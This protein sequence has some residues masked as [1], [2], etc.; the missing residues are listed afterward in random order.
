MEAGHWKGP[1]DGIGAAVKRKADSM[2]AKGN[3]LKNGK[4]IYEDL[5]KEQSNVKLFYITEQE[6]EKMDPLLPDR[7]KTIRGTTENTPGNI[8]NV[9]L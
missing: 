1:A 4:V 6:I 9:K 2:V 7:L 5:S 3:N 8:Y